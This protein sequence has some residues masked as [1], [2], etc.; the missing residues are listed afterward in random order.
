MEISLDL[1]GNSILMSLMAFSDAQNIPEFS[2]NL[3]DALNFYN[4]S[5][6]IKHDPGNYIQVK[7]TFTK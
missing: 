7:I 4:A 1:M 2:P 6:E 5:Y 3:N